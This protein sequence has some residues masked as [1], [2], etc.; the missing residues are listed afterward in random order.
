MPPLAL[1]TLSILFPPIT[2]GYKRGFFSVKE[3]I[4]KMVGCHGSRC[5]PQSSQ[6]CPLLWWVDLEKTAITFSPLIFIF[7]LKIT[8][9]PVVGAPRPRNAQL[10]CSR[11]Q[12]LG[13]GQH[14]P[15]RVGIKESLWPFLIDKR[16]RQT[17]FH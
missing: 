2:R 4:R 1:H 9:S 6:I 7:I 8:D 14:T 15:F 13:I 11:L 5:N 17:V 16:W 10:D 3:T 12:M